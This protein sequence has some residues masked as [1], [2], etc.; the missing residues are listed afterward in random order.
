MKK[1]IKFLKDNAVM[2]NS[3]A[4]KEEKKELGDVVDKIIRGLEKC[5][6]QKD[7]QGH[8][9]IRK[10]I[11]DISEVY[12][13]EDKESLALRIRDGVHLDEAYELHPYIREYRYNGKTL[14]GYYVTDNGYSMASCMHVEFTSDGRIIRSVGA[15]WK[16][17]TRLLKILDEMYRQ[18]KQK[19]IVLPEH[20]KL[21]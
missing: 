6:E 19:H 20:I 15:S 2:I 13:D 8:Y 9:L 4:S 17:Y 11:S 21:L 16:D 5:D 3:L 10:E 7:V 14:D 12:F 1:I 18:V